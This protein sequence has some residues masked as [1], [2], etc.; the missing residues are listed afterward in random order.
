MPLLEETIL[1]KKAKMKFSVAMEIGSYLIDDMKLSLINMMKGANEEPPS[2]SS[3][4]A[5][6]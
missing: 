2:D 5:V 6:E 4:S 1:E 3:S